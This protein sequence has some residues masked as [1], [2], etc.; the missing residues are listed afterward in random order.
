ML[1][2]VTLRIHGELLLP[3]NVPTLLGVQPSI[4]RRKGEITKSSTGKDIVTKFGIWVW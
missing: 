2:S 3:V 4:A 1:I